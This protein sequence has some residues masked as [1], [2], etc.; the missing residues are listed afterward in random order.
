MNDAPAYDAATAL[1]SAN[2]ARLVATARLVRARARL[3]SGLVLLAFVLCHLA[4]HIFLIVSLPLANDMLGQLMMFWWGQ[5][6]TYLLGAVLAIHVLNALWSIYIRRYLRLPLWEL[7]QLVLG[8]TIPALLVLHTVGTKV[9]DQQL[10][11]SSDYYS[12]LTLHW[13]VYPGLVALQTVAVLTLWVHACIGLHF[14]LRIKRWYPAWRAILGTVAILIPTLAIAGYVS[15]GNQIRRE[16]QNPDF[17]AGVMKSAGETPE[18]IAQVMQMTAIGLAIYAVLV[19]LPF[20]GR[21][22]RG[23]VQSLHRQPRLTHANGQVLAM[24]PGAT[25]LE[26]LRAYGIPHASVCGGR[27]RCTTCRIRVSRGLATLPEPAGLEAMALSRIGAGDSVR[28][29][30]QIRPTADISIMPMLA[31]DS[32]AAD[33]LVHGGMEGS[34]RQVTVVFIDLRGST[35]LGE[36]KMPYDVLF[37]LNQFFNEMTRALDATGGHYSNFTGDGLMALYGLEAAEAAFG[38]EQ[39]LRGAREM[40]MR[41]DQLNTRL[42][43]D[44]KEPLRIGIGIHVGEAIVGA[45]GPSGSQIVTAIGDT[46]NTTARLEGLT[47]DYDPAFPG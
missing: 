33:G 39:A 41:L 22:V 10:G 5:I 12:V 40:L 34:E 17:V 18:T 46:V 38:A 21:G 23:A 44:L 32:S 20:A 14:W 27:A 31:A 43:T 19:L 25:V 30:C 28:L 16:A 6:G 35:T 47:K 8:L 24:L 29:A 13:V 37:I 3:V 26:T 45:L 15:G 11:T 9:A 2:A 7:T 42:R 36:A 1:P 4:S